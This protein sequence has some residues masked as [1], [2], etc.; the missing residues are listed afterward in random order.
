MSHTPEEAKKLWC[1]FVS[2]GPHSI[3]RAVADGVINNLCLA[4]GCAMWS[5]LPQSPERGYCG[6]KR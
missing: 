5:K 6:A 1:P 3:N 2:Y 4:D